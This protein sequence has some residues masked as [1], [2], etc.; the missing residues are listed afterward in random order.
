MS[1]NKKDIIEET[2]AAVKPACEAAPETEPCF[3][4]EQ[5]T[6]APAK[7]KKTDKKSKAKIASLEKEIE[8]LKKQNEEL[9]DKYLR[10]MAEYQN[11]RARSQKEKDGIYSDALSDSLKEM[12]PLFDNFERAAQFTEAEKVAEGLAMILKT[13]PDVLGKMK[14]ESFGEPG[15]QFDPAI[16]NAVMHEDSDERG[17][18]EISEVFQKGYRTGDKIIR[19]AMVKVAN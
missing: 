15:E 13:I 18:N 10:I 14:V 3:E 8:E 7:E 16:H 12:L 17:E 11:F 5:S 1:E 19:Y 4:E 6:E 9:N 2:E